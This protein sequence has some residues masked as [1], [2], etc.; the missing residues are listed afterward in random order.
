M[1]ALIED[2]RAE[3]VGLCRSASVSRLELFGSA[4]RADFDS[5]HSDL[6]FLVEFDAAPASASRS[7]L[8]T[9]FGFKNGLEALFGRPVD[10]LMLG[11]VRNPFIRKSP[12]VTRARAR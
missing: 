7:V 12:C 11:A 2:R 10:L 3:L 9:Y 6:D 1:L 8:S 4:A 5:V